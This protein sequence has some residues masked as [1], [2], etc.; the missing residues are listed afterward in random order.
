[1]LSK[2]NP[3]LQ[4]QYCRD[5]ERA[6]FGKAPTLELI[7]SAY[8]R[9]TAESWLEIQLNDL[10][11]FAGCKEKLRKE[12]ISELAAMILEDYAPY[13]L[14]EFMLFFQ[15][16]K[17]CE[18]GKFYG[19]V[20]PMVILQALATFEADR[21]EVIYKKRKEETRI[22][23][24]ACNQEHEALK[25]RYKQRVPD[26]FTDNAPVSFPQYRLMG[27]DYMDDATLA[28]ELQAIKDGTKKIPDSVLDI[29]AM[30]QAAF[31]I[32]TTD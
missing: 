1:M 20:D 29:Y 10:S 13:K 7:R 5:P 12:Q 30:V 11:E 8:G 31:N 32:K 28:A 23:E 9:N 17:R 2:F 6:F 26:A 18:Y 22:R 3:S 25:K 27:Y 16:F 19:A 14:T 24:E 21:R 15:R 4:V